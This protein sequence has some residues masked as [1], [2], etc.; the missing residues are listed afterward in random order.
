M[1]ESQQPVYREIQEFE[2]VK[3]DRG[4]E[5]KPLCKSLTGKSLTGVAQA[6]LKSEY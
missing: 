3:C 5:Q 6:V 2:I 1:I 4:E